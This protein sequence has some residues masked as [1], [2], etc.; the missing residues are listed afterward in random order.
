[1][2]FELF[3]PR[4]ALNK[5]FRKVK[6]NRAD[7]ETFKAQLS[8]LLAGVKAGESEEF[9]KNLIADFLK[10][11]YYDAH[12]IN[13]K[14]R[15]DL[16]VHESKTSDTPV[17]VI[18]ETK[19]PGNK[20]EMPTAAD[21][22]RK[23][24]HELVLYYLRERVTNKNLNVKHLIV[25]NTYE[26]FIFDAGVFEKAFVEHKAFAK[27]YEDFA[28]GRLAS[29]KTEF[30]YNSVAKPFIA[31]LNE[32]FPFTYVDL[33]DYQLD[34]GTESADEKKLITLY[35]LFSPEHLLKFP[36]ANDSNTL[37]KTFYAELLHIIGLT[38]V[39][40]GGKK[41]I[42]RQE[43][44]KRGDASLLENTI[45]QLENRDKLS[46]LDDPQTYGATRE[47]KLFNVAL[48][49]SITW[50][51]R[52]LFLKLL[53]SQLK[54]YHQNDADIGFLN[55][56]RLHNYD[57][58]NTLFFGVLARPVNERSASVGFERVPYL[59]SSLFE[60][61]EL[62]HLTLDMSALRDERDLPL[63]AGTVLK[64][65]QG[66]RRTGSLNTLTYLFEF[67][68]AYDFSS[69]GTETVQEERKTL[70]NASVLGLIFE[71][72][73]GYK[74]GSFFTPGF[75]TMY[76]CRETVR[77]A[78]VQKFNEVKGWNC[79]TFGELYDKIDD[80]REA[81]AIINSVKVCDPAV[82]SGHFLVSALNELLSVKSELKVLLGE[83]GRTLRDYTLEVISDELVITDS[84]GELFAY[85]PKNAESQR[86]QK[87][88][89]LEKQTLIENCLFGVDINPNSIKICR[90]RLWIELLKHA[91]YKEDD[92]LETLPNI[93]INIKTGNSLISRFALDADL[94]Q[95]LKK[96]DHTIG[97]YQNAVN[98]YRNASSKEEKR[99]MERL[100]EAIKASFRLEMLANDPKI[101][102]HKRLRAKLGVNQDNLFA[103][104][105]A[106]TIEQQKEQAKIQKRL[107]V[108]EKEIA[109][110]KNNR[111]FDQAFEWRF[112]FPEVLDDNGD[113]TGFDVV[114]GNP[115]YIRIQELQKSDTR[116]VTYFKNEYASA[117]KG[118][119]DIY[120]MFVE[121][122]LR[123]LN[124]QGHLNYILP[125]KFFNAKYGEPIREVIS[126]GKHLSKIVHFGDE[127]I[128]EGATTYV[129]LL[130]LDKSP[131]EEF[132]F[133]KVDNLPDWIRSHETPRGEIASEEVTRAEWNFNVGSGSH[134]LQKLSAMPIKLANIADRMY[135]GPITSADTVFLFKQYEEVT[136]GVVKVKSKELGEWVD[137]ESSILK[138]VVRSG[139]I[140]RYSA[141]PQ[142]VVLFPYEVEHS[143]ARL[144][145]QAEMQS[146]YPL[147]WQY[148]ERNKAALEDRE[149]GKFKDEKWYRFGRTQNLG[150][151]EQ[152]KIML[153]YMTTELAAYLDQ[154]NNYYFINVTTGGYGLTVDAFDYSYLC[155]LL[156][157]RLLD[158]YLKHV[159]TNFRGGYVAANKQY[160][161]QLP[162]RTINFSDPADK[163]KHGAVVGLV[164][165]M[166][167]LHEQ[168]AIADPSER[169]HLEREI[170]ATDAQ[171]DR[172]VYRLYGLTEEEIRIV[173]GGV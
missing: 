164:E 58:L 156:N 71:K 121:Q 134:L 5:A 147:A 142:A 77:R 154:S 83:D 116:Q 97:S 110:V 8:T 14:E 69:E 87:T 74:D 131:N 173:E 148:L 12:A 9:H 29:G 35:K 53:E 81:N 40:E 3:E 45:I 112:E 119:Y 26:W 1:V 34:T 36:F 104:T 32:P 163:Q 10:K 120:V 68:D 167:L 65:A 130:F 51:N 137:I 18:L 99:G 92:Q 160:I 15:N 145:T 80:K 75:I 49:L 111:I 13:T 118:N 31:G 89:F 128:F 122:G 61:S 139:D 78:V 22:N 48:E 153:P 143:V 28:A 162:I 124:K 21:L 135:Q 149:K 66:K 168:K 94:K 39:K 25:T 84:D 72:I 76:M 42:V 7:F 101:L 102:E 93:D 47:E 136:E 113:F 91:Y 20:S 57:D 146:Y 115:P 109:E 59:N 64:D 17:A 172:L 19:K 24:L 152:P 125:H 98:T 161:E 30:F 158:Y 171:I 106:Q 133:Q 138:P 107:E 67:L 100:I 129:C 123:L 151:W 105:E 16:V 52:I 44:T 157:S 126:Q 103:D 95:A 170:A 23:A 165:T 141:S 6:P 166:L 155:G 159:S 46:R 38:E 55:A 108:L 50:V 56:N 127:Q 43:E 63:Y 54:S 82:G 117:G 70:I 37:D 62:E 86:V 144:Y 41:L 79:E 4:A 11:S 88:L 169:A 85:N 27:Q 60:L 73:N 114:I 140:R 150:L 33:R 90:L 2:N 96:S 132:E